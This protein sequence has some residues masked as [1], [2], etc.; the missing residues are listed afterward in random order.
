L[1]IEA[2]QHGEDRRLTARRNKS[3]SRRTTHASGGIVG[4][5]VAEPTLARRLLLALATPVIL[6]LAVGGVLG[7]QVQRLTENAEWVDHTDEVI[8][9]TADIQK[10]IVDQETAL[11]G[12]VITADP[13]FLEPYRTTHPQLLI[14]E[15][16]ALVVDNPGQI[17]RVDEL[18]DRYSHWVDL[19]EEVVTGKTPL[20]AAR[21]HGSMIGRKLMMDEVRRV[22]SGLLDV[23]RSLRKARS[24]SL[25]A[26]NKTTRVVFV[27]LF[28]AAALFLAFTSRRNLQSMAATFE[29]ALANER[30]ARAAIETEDWIRTGQMK[31]AAAVQGDM[32]SEEVGKRALDALTAYL[33][34]EVGVFFTADGSGFRRTASHA[35]EIGKSHFSP[36][37]GLVG[38]AAEKTEPTRVRDLPPDYLSIASATGKTSPTELLLL[39][40]YVEG[41][42]HAI[43]EL[44]FR[45]T[46]EERELRLAS[47]VGETIAIAIR[48]AEYKARLQELLEESQRQGE[49]LQTQQEEL[50]VANEELTEQSNALREAQRLLEERQEE[51]EATNASL[52]EQTNELQRAQ[53]AL[54]DKANELERASRYKSEFLA[55][56][57]H[58]L[59]TPLNSTLILAKLLADNKEKNLSPEQV[60]YAE[61]IYGAGND[62][63]GLIND[64]LDLSK[65]EAGRMEVHTTRLP[66]ARLV[67]PVTRTFEPVAREKKLSFT[68]KLEPSLPPAMDG[69][70][71][72]VQQILKNLL[73]NAFKFTEKGEITLRAWSDGS[74]VRFAVQDSGIGIP[75]GQQG[76][77]FEAFRQ[78]DGTTNRKYGGT[79]LGLSI[80]RDLARLLGGEL[81]VES[82]PSRGSTF[83]LTLPIVYA[84]PATK[85]EAKPREIEAPRPTKRSDVAS[86]PAT[87]DREKLDRSQRLLLVVEDDPAFGRILVDLAHELEFQC[88]VAT[89]AEEGLRLATQHVPTA[90]ILDM[91][92]PDHSGLT[93]L[94]RLKR[95]PATRH[96]PVHVVSVA[97]YTQQAL[98]MGAMGYM[99]KPV[100]REELV[101]ALEA[102][103]QRVSGRMKRLLV[104]EDD[105][106]QRESIQALLGGNDVQ[107]VAVGTATEALEHLRS[108]TFDCVVTDL[109]LP[110]RSGYDLLETM[111]SDDAYAFPPV[112][113]YTGRSLTAQ[114][115]QQLRKHSSS[116]IVKGARSPERL[117]DE[118][119]LFLHQVESEL[120]AERR[121]MLQQARDREKVFENRKI[122][123]VEDD[124]RNV[125]ALTSL[126]EP[127]GAKIV[128][129]RNGLEGLAALAKNPDIDLVLMDIMMPEMDGLQATREIRKDPRHAKLPI[130]ALTAKAMRDDQE[131]CLAA[132]ANDYLSK[133]MDV[134]TLLSLLRVW[135]PK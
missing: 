50:R 46:I 34:S 122:L 100:K 31:V 6:L 23:E 89:T 126:L 10:Q 3:K 66:V 106:V 64:I 52:E 2:P 41:K 8:A 127:R 7:L 37:E 17:A 60:R 128:I 102:M 118:A 20:A 47:D 131:R 57:S 49:E 32:S 59:R 4:P 38:S 85:V 61:T 78:A 42:A 116:I 75:E 77:I 105:A 14:A 109:T 91:S 53:I 93:V 112:I 65:I 48:S 79:G 43:V 35:V 81:T 16:R 129:A 108:S 111:A 63:L 135:M 82:A 80:S 70:A 56:M 29:K 25:A 104:V 12:Y 125:F 74:T 121:R 40:A 28:A 39:P 92:L 55:N 123:V 30:E 94:D 71:Q 97:D 132:G 33:G 26:T 115:E 99:L 117:L 87:D 110:D 51:L 21:E 98:T 27:A 58:E 120:P 5:R 103:Q 44:A 101:Q 54:G 36:G 88:V 1:D 45:R 84:G 90:V 15:L 67:E 22:T 83:T 95:N 62:L 11:R 18:R 134:E 114:E 19:A 133:P 96:V 76:L 72:K 86:S 69:D 107:T 124:V 73:S 68:V 119:T 113:V 9:K 24:D 130:I 13:I